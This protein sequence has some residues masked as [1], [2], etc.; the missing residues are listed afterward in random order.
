[1]REV[2]VGGGGAIASGRNPSPV[3]VV[4]AGRSRPLCRA[5]RRRGGGAWRLRRA[6]RRNRGAQASACG[7]EHGESERRAR[8]R[9][10]I[11]SP[12]RV[13]PSVDFALMCVVAERAMMREGFSHSRRRVSIDASSG[14]CVWG[15]SEA[16]RRAARAQKRGRGE[17]ELSSLAPENSSHV[18]ALQTHV[19]LYTKG[20]RR[21]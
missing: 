8:E 3:V 17:E 1:M 10:E 21:P 6:G 16:R 11:G 20:A 5:A 2:A 4:A 18:N 15:W 13:F 19:V 7:R 14:L 9:K 12:E